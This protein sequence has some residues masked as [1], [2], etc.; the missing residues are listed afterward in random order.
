MIMDILPRAKADQ[1]S[2]NVVPL[3]QQAAS[4]GDEGD[5]ALKFVHRQELWES[6]D[7]ENDV[8]RSLKEQIGILGFAPQSS[9]IG[10]VDPP[11]FDDFSSSAP[12]PSLFSNI[13]PLSNSL[14]YMQVEFVSGMEKKELLPCASHLAV[15][16]MCWKLRCSCTIHNFAYPSISHA[17][18]SHA[19]LLSLGNLNRSS[20]DMALSF[21]LDS[22]DIAVVLTAWKKYRHP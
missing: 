7:R 8:D 20:V 12:S 5:N 4:F 18:D 22:T 14:H 10:I 1:F 9:R 13:F 6:S 15:Q 17:L 19:S 21:T 11:S 2:Y 3:R 16:R